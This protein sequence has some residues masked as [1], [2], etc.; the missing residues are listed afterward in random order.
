MRNSTRAARIC[1]SFDAAEKYDQAA[2][3]QRVAA[4]ELF[5]RIHTCMAGK[6]PLRI[7][8]IGCGTGLLTEHLR[9]CWPDADILATDF[10]PNMLARAKS[11][12]GESVSY[13]QMDAATPDVNGPF[14]LICG[15][16]IMQWLPEPA[17]ALR[18]LA[19]ILAPG[20]VLAVSTLLDGTFAEWQQACAQEGQHAATPVYPELANAQNWRPSAFSGGWVEQDIVQ[21]FADGLDFVRHLKATGASTPR[22]GSVPLSAVQ[23]RHVAL[24]FQ[25]A[26]CAITWRVGYAC[27]RKPLRKGVFVTGTDTG[28][29][30]T[31]VSACLVRR[32]QGAYW[33]PLQS[34]LADEEGDTPT[35]K[36]LAG[37][38]PCFKPAG[39][40]LAPLSPD[41]AA[42]AEGVQ[43][44][45]AQ[46]V[47][48][49]GEADKPLVVEGAGGLMVPATPDLMMIDLAQRWGLPVVLV[50]RSGLGTLNHTLLS[51]EA[52]R[53]RQIVVA[54]VVLSGPLNAENRETIA[55][56]AKVRILAE[57]PFCAEITPDVVSELAKLFPQWDDM[58]PE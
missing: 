49:Q 14:D 27:F 25:Q 15:N 24:R 38:P 26:G 57:V 21:A 31:L 5:Q 39:A 40:F 34:G 33:K 36:L 45:P 3:V 22:E 48:P 18:T 56:K 20:G 10:A 47:L 12:L 2:T 58:C 17:K 32:W 50:A 7:L 54:G 28:I 1:Q 16:L 55:Q 8:E 44:D 4:R 46:L 11:R 52:L 35:V 30:K 43:I 42:R 53:A 41:A 13:H 29:G 37:D 23:L 51:L 9:A 6:K 19:E